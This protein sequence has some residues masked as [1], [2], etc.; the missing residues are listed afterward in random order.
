MLKLVSTLLFLFW[1]LRGEMKN[2]N[3]MVL[4]CAFSKDYAYVFD[5]TPGWCERGRR[6]GSK[7][8]SAAREETEERERGSGKEATAGAGSGTEER[9]CTVCLSDFLSVCFKENDTIHR[10]ISLE[11]QF[12]T[13]CNNRKTMYGCSFSSKGSVFLF[14]S[15]FYYFSPPPGWKQRRSSRR[16]MTKKREGTTLGMNIW[17]RSSSNWWRTWMKS[18]S[19][20]Q[21]VSRRSH[22]PSPSTGTSWTRLFPLWEQQVSNTQTPTQN[23]TAKQPL[24]HN[25]LCVIVMLQ[26]C[27]LEASRYPV[28]L[29]HRSI[30]LTMTETSQITGR[31]TGKT[32]SLPIRC[33]ILACQQTTNFFTFQLPGKFNKNKYWHCMVIMCWYRMLL[34][35]KTTQINFFFQD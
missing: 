19:L 5:L 35:F 33:L 27:V 7:E 8:G 28:F 21:E 23:V 9:S 1:F 15:S 10:F 18:S 25:Y 32:H 22:V 24:I 3:I 34:S 12:W 4:N 11:Q 2:I 26:G 20:D 16:R 17:G 6:R 13:V 14:Q 29:W 30:W 31:T